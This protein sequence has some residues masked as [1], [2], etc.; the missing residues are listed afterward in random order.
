MPNKISSIEGYLKSSILYHYTSD[1][2]WDAMHLRGQQGLLSYRPL[3]Q[4]E[5]ASTLSKQALRS[6]LFGLEYFE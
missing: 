6:T 3:I 5:Y 4:R 2:C 1:I